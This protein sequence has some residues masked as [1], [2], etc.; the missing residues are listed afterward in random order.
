RRVERRKEDK[1]ISNHKIEDPHNTSSRAN[2]ENENIIPQQAK[3]TKKVNHTQT[4]ETHVLTG[5]NIKNKVG[6]K[7]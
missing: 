3:Q 2:K 5:M 4:I 1:K 6:M 7:W